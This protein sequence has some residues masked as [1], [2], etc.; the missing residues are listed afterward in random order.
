[1]ARAAYP[2]EHR[3][4]AGG[5]TATLGGTGLLERCP[6]L[7]VLITAWVTASAAAQTTAADQGWTF[8]TRVLVTGS[9]DE[10]DPPGYQVYST[11]ALEAGLRRALGT[12]FSAE[13]NVHTE[14]REVDSLVPGGE[15]R[16]L[17]SLEL[18]PL[19]FFL[20]YRRSGGTFHPYAGLGVN[21]TFA[22]EKSGVLDS[23]DMQPGFGP[24]IQIG[25]DLDLSSQVLLNADLRWNRLRADL[26][27]KG[28]PLTGIRLDPLA[29]GVG[30]GFRF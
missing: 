16:R 25:A 14:S 12:A 4:G 28:V 5:A 30:L 23:V 8:T 6:L 3:I 1:V 9:S 19:N 22:W 7:L 15:D 11:F 26:E 17:G 18:L 13:L 21:A 2:I 20:Q 10:S 27:N 29:L 24:A